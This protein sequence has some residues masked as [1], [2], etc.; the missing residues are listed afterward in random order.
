MI[1]E[2]ER[3]GFGGGEVPPPRKVYSIRW[4]SVEKAFEIPGKCRWQGRRKPGRSEARFPSPKRR[5]RSA[6]GKRPWQRTAAAPTFARKCGGNARL[7]ARMRARETRC[8]VARSGRRP[9]HGP[10]GLNKAP[11]HT[12][13]ILK[14]T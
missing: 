13:K 8:G 14:K 9:A 6:T 4:R 5:C 1:L 12:K 2:R 10:D 3:E 7:R 11:H